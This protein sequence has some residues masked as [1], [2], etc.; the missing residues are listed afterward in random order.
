MLKLYVKASEAVRRLRTD[1]G[2]VVSFEYVIL[3]ACVVIIVTAVF[4]N[5]T[6]GNKLNTAINNINLSP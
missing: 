6:I 2:G 4:T 1:N 5:G 3:A